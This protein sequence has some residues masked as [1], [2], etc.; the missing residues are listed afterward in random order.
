MIERKNTVIP[1][2]LRFYDF[3]ITCFSNKQF[4]ILDKVDLIFKRFYSIETYFEN[5]KMIETLN[6]KS[7]EFEKEFPLIYEKL[8]LLKPN[9]DLD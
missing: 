6:S 2:K 3:I 9:T 8:E 7:I 5:H 1:I 4:K